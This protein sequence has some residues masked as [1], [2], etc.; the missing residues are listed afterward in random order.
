MAS[1]IFFTLTDQTSSPS[2]HLKIATGQKKI[3]AFVLSP[4]ELDGD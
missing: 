2:K 1:R 3:D 4:K